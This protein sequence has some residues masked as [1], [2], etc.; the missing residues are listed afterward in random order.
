V[1][2]GKVATGEKPFRIMRVVTHLQ[3]QARAV[4]TYKW[5]IPEEHSVTADIQTGYAGAIR[6]ENHHWCD[7]SAVYRPGPVHIGN[8]FTT[9]ETLAAQICCDR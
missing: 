3:C 2:D 1:T 8:R 9:S 4:G 6:F 7:G 5:E